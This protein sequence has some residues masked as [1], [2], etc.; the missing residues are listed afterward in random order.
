MGLT[1]G[2]V[3]LVV[4]W[5]A[6]ALLSAPRSLRPPAP[7]PPQNSVDSTVPSRLVLRLMHVLQPGVPV[8]FFKCVGMRS[9]QRS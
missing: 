7:S 2:N 6:K 1:R 9:H 3:L 4:F 8:L 5:G